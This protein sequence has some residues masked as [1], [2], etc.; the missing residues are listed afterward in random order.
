MT[1]PAV[2]YTFRAALVRVIDGDTVVLKI[3]FRA[4]RYGDVA[5]RLLGVNAPELHGATAAAGRAARDWVLAWLCRAALDGG[6]W[7]LV[8][9]TELDKDDKFGRLLAH[10]WRVSD[11][12]RLSDDLLGSGH[13]VTYD[14]KGPR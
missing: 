5:V 13:A 12:H 8:V 9:E 6:E 1:I 10:V 11:E 14:G 3:D 4:H 7:P 2:P